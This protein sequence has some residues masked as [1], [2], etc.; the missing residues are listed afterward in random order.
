MNIHVTEHAVDRY[1]ERV[2]PDLSRAGAEYVLR[3]VLKSSKP[4]KQRTKH[5]QLQYVMADG[6]R[7]IVKETPD[8]LVLVTIYTSA[9]TPEVP[10]CEGTSADLS[11]S[12]QVRRL[13]A[14][15]AK[16][17]AALEGAEASAPG[18]KPSTRV[19]REP[20]ARNQQ[21]A[22]VNFQL[23]VANSTFRAV[24]EQRCNPPDL[25][26]LLDTYRA[27]LSEICAAP[28]ALPPDTE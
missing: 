21:V 19:Q 23:V 8:G 20:A 26:R 18:S 27:I 13:T 5:G 12:D 7:L 2:R 25:V 6:N 10:E 3:D 9:A 4:L 11:L 28:V 22:A 1:R 17:R 15:N 14:E 24:L 16:L